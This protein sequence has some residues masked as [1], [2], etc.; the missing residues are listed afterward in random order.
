MS[1][2][3]RP[4]GVMLG[5]YELGATLGI[6]TFGKVKLAVHELTGHKVAVK[7][8]NRNK[9]KT[10]SV[11]SKL[12]R[13][14]EHMQT[15]RHPHVIKL[16]QVIST[17]TDIFLIMEY[18]SGGELFD[19]IVKQQ[20]LEEPEARRYFQQ[21]ISGV[22][23]CHQNMIVHRDLKPENLLL[24][25]NLNVKIADFG[26]SNFMT[27]GEFLD[28][29]CGSPNYAAPEV[30]SGKL[31]AG[32]EVDIWSCG[33]ILYALLCGS[34]PFEDSHVPNLFKKIRAGVYIIPSFVSPQ[35]ASLVRIMLQVDPLKRA[36]VEH[37]RSH[38]WFAEDL[39][40][41]LFPPDTDIESSVIDKAALA[42]VCERAKCTEKELLRALLCGDPHDPLVVAYHLSIDSKMSNA[43]RH[44]QQPGEVFREFY[45]ASAAEATEAASAT[46]VAAL[47]VS[48]SDSSGKRHP[49]QLSECHP[50]Y[51]REYFPPGGLFTKTLEPLPG[52]GAPGKPAHR[53][54]WHLGIRSASRPQD[55]MHEVMK[56]L[57]RSGFEW[58]EVNEFQLIARC[59]CPVTGAK[60][61]AH[62]QLYSIEFERTYLV[63]IRLMDQSDRQRVCSSSSACGDRLSMLSL[64]G[65]SFDALSESMDHEAVKTASSEVSETLVPSQI[66]QFLES[67]FR[68]ITCL[69]RP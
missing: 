21:I 57:A 5:H 14:I 66:I 65:S 25:S 24:D 63:D 31:Y 34:L 23:Y 32:P 42:E 43:V 27:D 11:A 6:G 41:Y 33:I 8:V 15:F 20:R 55:I 50:S 47:D 29:S 16:Y 54:K 64:S 1:D 35:A 4:S 44:G 60:L 58:R 28:T 68:L 48:T 19:R 38:P 67:A 17:P 9:I 37:I 30:V 52:Q 39:P 40:E 49:R 22:D 18:V 45:V 59:T 36:T 13:E 62:L 53:S 56:A 61:H 2:A 46:A 10:L 51:H 26:L 69:T 12:R 7:I 3:E